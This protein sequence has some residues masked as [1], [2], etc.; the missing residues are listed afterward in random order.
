[1]P[2]KGKLGNAPGSDVHLT[3]PEIWERVMATLGKIV[4]DPCP[5]PRPDG[6]CALEGG[7]WEGPFYLNPPFSDLDAFCEKAA[8]SAE[9]I[10]L[11]PCRTSQP[12]WGTLTRA[13]SVVAY[14]TGDRDRGGKLPRRIRFLDAFGVRQPGAPFDAAL[15]LLSE[16]RGTQGAF[17]DAFSDV[18]TVVRLHSPRLRPDVMRIQRILEAQS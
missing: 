10:V 15:F 3:P 17:I 4:R 18:A 7:P 9:G 6:H 11:V 14:W 5:H 13:A 2:R 8:R 12:Y 1:M 16:S